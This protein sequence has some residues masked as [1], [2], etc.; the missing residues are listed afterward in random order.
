MEKAINTNNLQ[1]T[2]HKLFLIKRDIVLD[3]S[4]YV[5]RYI[6][7][8][9]SGYYAKGIRLNAIEGRQI[10]R[11][12]KFVK[13]DDGFDLCVVDFDFIEVSAECDEHLK[14]AAM[15]EKRMENYNPEDNV[16]WEDI[17]DS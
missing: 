4:D 13:E 10:S 12:L 17:K 15:I 2:M 7:C 6:G 3:R 1:F 11:Y 5:R 14:I 9:Y 16:N 8:D